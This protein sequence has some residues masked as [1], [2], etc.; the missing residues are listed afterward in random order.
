LFKAKGE[1]LSTTTIY[2]FLKMKNIPARYRESF[3]LDVVPICPLCRGTKVIHAGFRYKSRTRERLERKFKCNTCGQVFFLGRLPN[4]RRWKYPEWLMQFA[5]HAYQ[6]PRMNARKVSELIKARFDVEIASGN[7]R[8]WV[9]LNHIP[10]KKPWETIRET[11][12][13]RYGENAFRPSVETRRKISETLKGKS[14]LSK[15]ARK[16]NSIRMLNLWA[17]PNFR[18]KMSPRIRE[19]WIRRKAVNGY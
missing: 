14:F 8:L 1:Y 19:G 18:M 5:V 4:S 15:E 13:E 11:K 9:I 12:I 17:D 2:E 3:P 6:E 10:T 7:I 16:R